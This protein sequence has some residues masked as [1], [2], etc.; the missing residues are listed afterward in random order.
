MAHQSIEF[1]EFDHYIFTYSNETAVKIIVEP[2]GENEKNMIR[3][4][5]RT[6][7]GKTISVKCDKPE[8][9]M[10]ILDEVEKRSAIP[11]STTY[12]VHRGKLLNKIEK[13][14][15]G[16]ETTIDTS[17]RLLGGIGYERGNGCTGFR[18]RWSQKLAEVSEGKQTRPSG[19]A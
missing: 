16:K 1:Y 4:Y 13:D 6:G 12:L 15:L 19:D 8:K 11:R 9:A 18:R 17:L 5:V 2:V 14:N 7:S 3:I 10:T